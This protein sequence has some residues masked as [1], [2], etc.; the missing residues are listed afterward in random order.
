MTVQ[1]GGGK[2]YET[3]GNYLPAIGRNG[4]PRLTA[5]EAEAIAL[6]RGTESARIGGETQLNFLSPALLGQADEAVYL[7]WRE[8]PG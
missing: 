7:V 1:L 4:E 3:G 2:V 8:P 5:A 6:G